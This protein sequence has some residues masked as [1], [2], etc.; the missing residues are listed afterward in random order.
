MDCSGV[1][2]QML[3]VLYGEADAETRRLV[4]EHH[5]QCP[6]CRHELAALHGVRQALGRWRLPEARPARTFRRSGLAAAAL[7]LLS[8]G[9][10][11][12][13]SG[14]EIRLENGRLAWRIGRSDVEGRLAE[15]EARHQAEIAKLRAELATRDS[16]L[17]EVD[18]RIRASEARQA[19]L[20]SAG[21]SELTARTAAQRRYDLARVSASLSYL[22]GRT[23]QQLA[24]QSELMGYLLQAADQR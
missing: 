18:Q 13:F 19:V 22:D 14:S 2:D 8:L 10:A 5:A 17:L 20:L 24:E 7:V 21:L 15:Q 3:D 11:L 1:R 9:A 12:G 6:S 4:A 16:L 23:G